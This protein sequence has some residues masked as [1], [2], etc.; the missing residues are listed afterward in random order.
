M[1]NNDDGLRVLMM[2]EDN[3]RS[4]FGLFGPLFQPTN[5]KIKQGACFFKERL[6]VMLPDVEIY[7]KSRKITKNLIFKNRSF[8]N[9]KYRHD[10]CPDV[11]FGGSYPQNTTKI[12]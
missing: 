10:R 5:V 8:V 1:I 6:M 2:A 4:C 3:S 11:F 12:F 7:L 9:R